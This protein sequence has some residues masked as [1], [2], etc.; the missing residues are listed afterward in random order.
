MAARRRSQAQS[1][2]GGDSA[3]LIAAAGRRSHNFAERHA[4]AFRRA[5]LG[6]M[7][8]CAVWKA[9][10]TTRLFDLVAQANAPLCIET[11]GARVATVLFGAADLA[12]AVRAAPVRFVCDGSFVDL[13]SAIV[14][15][16]DLLSRSIDLVRACSAELWL[17]W[18]DR[19]AGRKV[20]LLVSAS[21]CGRS[22]EVQFCWSSFESDEGV[23]VSPIVAQ[24]DFADP[25][26]GPG[27]APDHVDLD[28]PPDHPMRSLLRHVRFRM[29][30]DWLRYYVWRVNARDLKALLQQVAGMVVPDMI[31]FCAAMLLLMADGLSQR[32]EVRAIKASQGQWRDGAPMLDHTELIA[33]WGA[34]FTGSAREADDGFACKRRLHPVRGHF[35][36]WRDRLYWRRPH[37]RGD[38]AVGLIRSR[39]VSLRGP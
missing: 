9:N 27:P 25:D 32:R 17:E 22:G 35:V 6:G 15:D 14:G 8:P 10:S 31:Q 21:E 20:G 33:N 18:C 7:A 36:R 12:A 26:F 30:R 24:F 28:L 16:L 5:A 37:L 34:A 11:P 19:A 4:N 1:W 3:A 2:F 38:A 39:T 23:D 13:S 29:R